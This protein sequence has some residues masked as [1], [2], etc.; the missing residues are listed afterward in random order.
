MSA[1]PATVPAWKQRPE[2][3][4]FFA[5]WLICTIGRRGG[6]VVART[7]LW[8]ITAYFLLVRGPE[9][10]ASRAYLAR[11][12][13]VRPTLWHVAR[14][15]HTFASTLLDRVYLLAGELGR[16]EFDVT[17]LA[18]LD[19]QLARGKGVLLLGAH[20]GSF[21]ALRALATRRPELRVRVLL[22]KAH[23]AS[24]QHLLDA[25][26]PQL[27]AEIIDAGQP[28]TTTVL[29][30][31]EALAEGALVALLADRMLP[32][33]DAVSVPFL[34]DPARFPL[35]PW[36][37]AS[38]LQVPVCLA[39]GLYR[40]GNRFEVLFEPL[41]DGLN[42]PRQQRAQ[43]VAGLVQAYAARVQHHARRAPYNWF[44]FYEFW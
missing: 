16:F 19:A 5:L 31:R 14:H 42:M 43:A 26:N 8:P 12:L 6:R 37:I 25:L 22:D 30:I 17:G 10:R 2:G 21:D 36:Q 15:I 9:R 39:F 28:G 3:G 27:A 23:N 41:S 44:N 40:G 32:G 13:P 1:M 29:A 38:V 24:Q 18:A 33:A 20:L 35:A 11:V 7:L 34:G 4:G